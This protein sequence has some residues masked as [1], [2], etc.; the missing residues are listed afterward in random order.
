MTK[1]SIVSVFLL[2][3]LAITTRPSISAPPTSLCE[4]TEKI[5]FSCTVKR[6]AKIVSLCSSK[7]FAKDRG[8]LQYRFGLPGKVELEFPKT[9]T[10]TQEQFHYSHYF[11]Y[12][13][14][15]T[16]ISFNLDG[17]EYEIFDSYQ[18]EEKP[19]IS[20]AGVN[21]TAPGKSKETSFVCRT[22]A[23]ADYGALQDALPND[24]Q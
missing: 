12:Q 1:M 13:V 18:G 23:K 4:A 11:R 6:S 19:A 16:E 20:E 5:I 10:R 3:S 24:S 8:Y 7:D 2:V 14:D 22:K 15:L 21:V 9:R 17:Y